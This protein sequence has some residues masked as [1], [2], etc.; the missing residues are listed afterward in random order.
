MWSILTGVSDGY[1]VSVLT[2]VAVDH[3]ENGTHIECKAVGI[4]ESALEVRIKNHTEF[5]SCIEIIEAFMRADRQ[6]I[7]E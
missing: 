1:G 6:L 3:N 7:R 4:N 2:M 5:A